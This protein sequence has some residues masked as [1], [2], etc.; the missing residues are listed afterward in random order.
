MANLFG[1]DLR[2]LF[3]TALGGKLLPVTLKVRSP[4]ATYDANDPGA[5]ARYTEMSYP[6]KG[7]CEVTESRQDG[8]TIR[9]QTGT[10]IILLGTIATAGIRPKA[11]DL[12]SFVPPGSTTS[13]DAVVVK[14]DYDPAGVSAVLTLS[15]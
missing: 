12:V 8:D 10:M 4:G 5:G 9:M 6:C 2:S 15:G 7:S 13:Q 14:A 1:Q 11:D 3:A